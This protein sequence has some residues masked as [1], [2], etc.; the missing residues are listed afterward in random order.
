MK[1]AI[2][3][4]NLVR[5]S[6][7]TYCEN[8][9][10]SRM[11][12]G[13]Q[14]Y[15]GPFT[16]EEVEDVKVLFKVLLSLSPTFFLDLCATTITSDHPTKLPADYFVNDTVRIVFLEYGVLSQLL[17]VICCPLVIKC[18]I[19]RYF[20]NMFKRMGLS[21]LLL[22]VLFTLY[23]RNY[24]IGGSQK[25]LDNFG[26]PCFANGSYNIFP[27][28]ASSIS[29]AYLLGIHNVIASL[30]HTFLYISIWEFICCQSPQHM[31]GL[32][33]ALFYAVSNFYRV[34]AVLFLILFLYLPKTQLVG[35][36]FIF[37]AVNLIIGLISFVIFA[38]L[39]YKYQYRKR[40]DICN[41]YQ[42]AEDYYSTTDGYSSIN[43]STQN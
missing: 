22:C 13:K 10:P 24:V 14:R 30:Y 43:N 28:I 17:T 20:P 32:L 35:C 29:P 39:T 8:R 1:F 42:Y 25:F 40:D 34:L 11:D 15:G 4:K 5:R 12:F 7:F 19:S 33:F 16:T 41:I 23:L 9:C 31:K 38:I 26:V 36:P 37:Y 3:H 18:F 27:N 21:L 6:A 2:Q